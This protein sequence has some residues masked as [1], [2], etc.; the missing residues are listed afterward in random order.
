MCAIP[1]LTGWA[2]LNPTPTHNVSTVTDKA[3]EYGNSKKETP[4]R[5]RNIRQERK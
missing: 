3:Y 5:A 1:K 4:F 2:P